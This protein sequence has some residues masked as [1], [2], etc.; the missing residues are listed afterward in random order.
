M[1]PEEIKESVM[2]AVVEIQTNSGRGIPKLHD[3]LRPVVDFEDFTSLNAVEATSLLSD[4]LRHE[5]P[6]NIM[7]SNN[8]QQQPTIGEI[9]ERIYRII[10]VQRGEQ[11]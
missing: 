2:Q 1:T 3:Q 11:H 9:A 5:L 10:N 7:F 4:L 6:R 8:P